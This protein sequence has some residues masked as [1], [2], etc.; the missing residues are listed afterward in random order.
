MYSATFTANRILL[1]KIICTD[2]FRWQLRWFYYQI[3]HRRRVRTNPEMRLLE[4]STR[5]S[6]YVV[7]DDNDELSREW[8]I[9]TLVPMVEDHLQKPM[10]FVRDRDEFCGKYYISQRFVAATCLCNALLKRC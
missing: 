8:V 3:R 4:S 10:M 7:Y 6:S 1:T 9:H 5:C 2:R